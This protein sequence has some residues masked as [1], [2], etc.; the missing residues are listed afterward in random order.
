MNTYEAE[1]HQLT[2]QIRDM[3]KAFEKLQS[4]KAAL[5]A[6]LREARPPS[7]SRDGPGQ[8]STSQPSFSQP[9]RPLR[10]TPK[11]WVCHLHL[12][13]PQHARLV[14]CKPELELVIYSSWPAELLA[15]T[16]RQKIEAFI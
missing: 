9:S 5:E 14:F 4:D 6:A 1:C 2:D 13:S 16:G 11:G 7:D 10:P 15:F 8:A 3:Q 12:H